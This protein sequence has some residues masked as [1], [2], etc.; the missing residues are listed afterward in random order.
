MAAMAL[1]AVSC[2][3]TQVSDADLRLTWQLA[4]TAPVVGRA[5]TA[6]V[7]LVDAQH[8]PVRGANLEIEAHMTHPGMAPLVVPLLETAGGRYTARV[9]FTMAGD[10][11]VFVTGQLGDGRQVRRQVAEVVAIGAAE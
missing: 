6:A 3:Q 9:S 8:E 4:T 5:T 11:V 10:W 7:T 2:R 1:A